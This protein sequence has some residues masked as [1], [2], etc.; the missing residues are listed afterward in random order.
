MYTVSLVFVTLLGLLTVGRIQQPAQM[1]QPEQPTTSERWAGANRFQTAAE[2]ARKSYPQGAPVVYLVSGSNFPD[3]LTAGQAEPPGPILFAG[4][5]PLNYYT[6]EA[7]NDLKP[8]RIIVVG[9]ASVVSERQR[10]T[11]RTCVNMSPSDAE[12]QLLSAINSER[13]QQGLNEVSHSDRWQ[14]IS[15]DWS[16]HIAVQGF[17]SHSTP[18]PDGYSQWGENVA[19]APNPQRIHETL[20]ESPPHRAN[21]LGVWNTAGVGVM[22]DASRIWVTQQFVRN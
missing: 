1:Q 8:T 12:A 16:W 3:A 17:L 2:V 4:E 21:I 10:D 22:V 19:M 6:C 7:I 20:M 9:G 13:R 15:R 11:A 5:E 18:P 14:R